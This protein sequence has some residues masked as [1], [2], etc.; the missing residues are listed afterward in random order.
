[1]EADGRAFM[2]LTGVTISLLTLRPEISAMLLIQDEN[3]WKDALS[4]KRGYK[5][6]T[7]ESRGK[8][9]LIPIESD[10]LALASLPE[11]YFLKIVPQAITAFWAGIDA[12]RELIMNH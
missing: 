7:P 8:L 6:D 5:L 4:G 10:E 11:N 3:W 9:L 1:M 2:R 12:A